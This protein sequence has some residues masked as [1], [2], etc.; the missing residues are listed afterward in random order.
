MTLEPPLVISPRLL[1]ALRV[2]GGFVS[3]E[4]ATLASGKPRWRYYIDGPDFSYEKADLRG[5]GD[6]RAMLGVLLSFLRSAAE[7]YHY[8]TFVKHRAELDPDSN[9]ALFPSNVV[10]WAYQYDGELEALALQLEE[11]EEGR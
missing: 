6:H 11:S 4:P 8:R 10:E 9:E 5:W 7:A 3:I 1:P 2:G